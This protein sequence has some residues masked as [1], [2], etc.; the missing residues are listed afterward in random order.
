MSSEWL[1]HEAIKEQQRACLEAI[2]KDQ[3]GGR[4]ENRRGTELEALVTLNRRG[5][6]SVFQNTLSTVS[7]S[8]SSSLFM[9]F[10]LYSKRPM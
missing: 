5:I 3:E 10:F 6:A 8:S 7:F 2:R 9:F 4:K 1:K